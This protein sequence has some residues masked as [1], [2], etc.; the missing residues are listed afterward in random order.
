MSEAMSE[1]MNGQRDANQTPKER[2]RN[3]REL[4][5]EFS[6]AGEMIPRVTRIAVHP[7]SGNLLSESCTEIEITDEGWGEYVK[8]LQIGC[9]EGIAFNPEEWPQIREA[10]DHMVKECR[11]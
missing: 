4:V 7:K 11:P 5:I 3:T 1:E 6:E 8:V 10:I 2:E 9:N